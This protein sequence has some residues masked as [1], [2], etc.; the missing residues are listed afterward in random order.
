MGTSISGTAAVVE[1]T[2]VSLAGG[3]GRRSYGRG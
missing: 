3:G 1:L 2:V